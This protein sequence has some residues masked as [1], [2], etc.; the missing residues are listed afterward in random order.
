MKYY[1]FKEKLGEGIIRNHPNRF[2]MDIEIDGK[3]EK[4]H[5]PV[6]G[7]IGS[8]DF[9]NTPCLF[10]ISKNPK[11]KTKYTIEAISKNKP[12]SKR[13]SWIG[14]NQARSND[15]VEF[16]LK[17]NFMEKIISKNSEIL[18]EKKL[19]NS[20]IDFQIGNIFLEVKTFVWNIPGPDQVKNK[21]PM[22][23]DRLIKHFSDLA[24]FAKKEN[25]R[26]IVLICSQYKAEPFIPPKNSENT[27][28]GKTV[29]RAIS[30]GVEN[31]Q[32]NLKFTPR[33][34][35]FDDYFKLAF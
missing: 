5:C 34:V 18:R 9:K 33:G 10:S 30:D 14:I 8:F 29:R 6:T 13:K 2:I 32:V 26:A 1:K 24:E 12:E 4:A 19:G 11:R 3:L 25:G 15:Y 31:W 28:I 7:K 16:F 23:L 21:P 35:Y 17:N 27:E 22:V 20:R